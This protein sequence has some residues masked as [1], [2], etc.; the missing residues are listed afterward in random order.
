[1]AIDNEHIEIIAYSTAWKFHIHQRM[2]LLPQSPIQYVNLHHAKMAILL[3]SILL[4]V[5]CVLFSILA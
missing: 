3:H 4:K 5:S 1:M 2:L